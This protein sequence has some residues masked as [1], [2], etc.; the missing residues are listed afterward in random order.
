MDYGL[1]EKKDDY[2]ILILFR[3]QRVKGNG[4][5]SARNINLASHP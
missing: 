5:F 3:C 1:N 4:P 2:I